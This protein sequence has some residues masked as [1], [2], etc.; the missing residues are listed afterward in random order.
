M[1]SNRLFLLLVLSSASFGQNTNGTISGTVTDASGGG[2]ANAQVTVFNTDQNAAIRTVTTDAEGNYSAPLLPIGNY[3]VSVE[4]PGFRVSRQTGVRLNVNDKLTVNFALELGQVTEE[5]TVQ[6]PSVQVQTQS[7]E[8]SNLISGTQVRELSINNRNFVQLGQLMPGVS[9]GTSDQVYVGVSNPSGQSNT[10]SYSVN[11]ARNSSN[12]WTIDGADNV[13]RGSNITLLNYPSVDALA[14]FRVL[15][16]EYSAEFG[17]AAGGQFNVVTKSGGS[18]FHGTVYEFVRNDAFTANSFLN[19]ANRVNL[20]TDGKARVPPL[21]YNN[22]G[23]TL[24]GPIYIPR[25]YNRD[26]NKTFFFVSQE[27]RRVVTYGTL[28]AFAPTREML[29]GNFPVPVCVSFSAGACAQ[30]S[31]TV[32]AINP[33]AQQYI[34][35]IFSQIPA[36]ASGN[37]VLFSAQ[38]NRFNHEQELYRLDHTFTQ[39]FSVFVRFLRDQIPTSEPGGLFG[40]TT[41]PFIGNTST[42]SPGRT[43][44][45]RANW[46]ITPSFLNET[47]YA[48]SYGAILSDPTGLISSARSSINVNLPFASTLALAPSL[49]FTG[50]TTVGGFGPYR[51]YDRNHEVWDNATR[52]FGTHTVR[53]GGQ[54]FHF[55][56]TENAAGGN[57]GS[58]NF[59]SLGAPTGTSAYLQ[60]FANFLQG[61]VASFTQASQ[62]ITPDI[63]AWQFGLYVQDDWRIRRN[64]TLNLGLRWDIYRQPWDDNNLLTNFDPSTYNR[65]NAPQI[66]PATGLLVANTGNTLNGIVV[67][68]QNKQFGNSP[69]GRKVANEDTHNFGPRVGIAWDPWGQGRFVVRS[70]YGIYYDPILVGIFEQNIFNNPPFVNS[71]TIQNT[72]LSNPAAGTAVVN[73]AP[74]ALRGTPV[75]YRTPYMQQWSFDM[76][77]QFGGSWVAD[78]G[79]FGSKGTH[80]IG[81]ADINTVQPG[82]ARSSGLFPSDTVFTT[83]NEQRL[84]ALRPYPGYNAINSIETWFNSNYN[85]LQASLEKRFSAGSL[86][87]LAYTWSKN[88]TDNRSDRSSA[89]QNVYTFRTSERGLAQFDRRHIFTASYVYDI[90]FFRRN[91]NALARTI[92]GGW[93]I[94]GIVR[95]ATGLPYNPGLVTS[96]DPA[97]LGILG[98]S[99]AGLR[100]NWVCNPNEGAPHTRAQWFNTSCLA[101]PSSIQATPGN[102][103]RSIIH[104]PGYQNWDFSLFKNFVLRESPNRGNIALQIRGETFNVFNHTNPLDPSTSVGSGTYGQIVSYRDPRILQLGAKLNF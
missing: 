26:R 30:T 33:V 46:T 56:K 5:V 86:L 52:I 54:L 51:D 57:Q 44:V 74:K 35:S 72:S 47:G 96:T 3:T 53:F 48:F 101:A 50:G 93:E 14:E 67:N 25:I 60:A 104:G 97:G 42:N 68:S 83:A 12:N 81:I 90:P 73:L 88:L 28:Q 20:G 61:N 6:A 89:P 92:L 82:L 21:R 94:S 13:D 84:N 100:P 75:P 71:V 45:A 19:N 63:M 7:A 37:N 70:G 79:Y 23:W 85:S 9:S 58:F 31:T 95:V 22:F 8:A 41:L 49:V 98:P 40:Q 32:G 76:Q 69:Y 29:Q 102:A 36:G 66:D 18:D 39:N 91:S 2:V 62:D 80:L 10:I 17:R 34:N 59:S 4:A 11:G 87:T 43:W 15:R 77:K 24:G 16:G 38:R 1:L 27:F 65:A 55:E 64:L 103:G 99:A 78:V